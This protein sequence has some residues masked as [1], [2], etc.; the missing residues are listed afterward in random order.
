MK[1]GFRDH[2]CL[3][4]IQCQG[5]LIKVSILAGTGGNKLRTYKLF[6]QIF[7][8]ENYCKVIMWSCHR[9]AFAKFRC[10]VAPIRLETGRDEGLPVDERVCPFC[11]ID[12]EDEM[13]VLL[14]CDIYDS[15]RSELLGKAVKVKYNF[16]LLSVIRRFARWWTCLPFLSNRCRRWNACTFELRYLW[17]Y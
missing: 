3:I 15:I 8:A 5:K 16:N 17:L 11:Q 14:N 1:S 12:V 4:I 6:K 13:H 7:Q 10:G 2:T 9:S